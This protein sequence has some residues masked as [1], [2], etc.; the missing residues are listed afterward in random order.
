MHK[1]IRFRTDEDVGPLVVS[2]DT[3]KSY[4]L[5]PGG[6]LFVWLGENTSAHTVFDG[7]K[8]MVLAAL[9]ALTRDCVCRSVEWK[10]AVLAK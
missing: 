7:D 5:T 1:F 2:I 3:I 9:T 8:G 4:E 10:E 6:I